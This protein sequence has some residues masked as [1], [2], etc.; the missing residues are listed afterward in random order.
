MF[1]EFTPMEYLQIDLANNYGLDQQNWDDR[2]AWTQSN[3]GALEE[4]TK[5]AKEPALFFAGVQAYRKAQAGQP[6]SYGIGLDATASGAQIL[7]LLISCLKSAKLCNV[8]DTGKREDFY[9]SIYEAM[10]LRIN[11]TVKLARK[12]V[13]SAINH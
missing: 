3:D 4:M 2:L 11:D 8:V 9:T 5:T 7:A 1:Q 6:I 13:K 10:L 12:Q